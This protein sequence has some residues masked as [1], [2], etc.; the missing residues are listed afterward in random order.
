MGME[1]AIDL[2]KIVLPSQIELKAAIAVGG[3]STMCS[4]RKKTGTSK[5]GNQ[6]HCLILEEWE[7]TKGGRGSHGQTKWT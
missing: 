4:E 2:R 1:A 5:R 7:D 6:S 3:N